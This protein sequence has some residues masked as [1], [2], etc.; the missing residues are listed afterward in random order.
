MHGFLTG[1]GCTSHRLACASAATSS[2]P[3]SQLQPAQ[4]AE[5]RGQGDGDRAVR[6]I[7]A[8]G[9]ARRQR[10]PLPGAAPPVPPRGE[11][12]LRGD[13]RLAGHE[14]RSE[15]HRARR[16]RTAPI[17][18]KP[19]GCCFGRSSSTASRFPSLTVE[20]VN[21]FKWFLAAPPARW[22]GPRHHQRWSPLWRPLEGPLSSAALRQS[23]VILRSLFA[24]LVSQNYSAR[25]RVR[26]RGAAARAERGRSA[27]RER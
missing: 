2:V 24:F 11:E 16:R 18:R 17:E 14:A 21:A 10:R 20:D 1:C 19:S 7:P 27:R 26:G 4:L 3:R 15:R 12:R 8:A 23:I 22:C 13:R 6:K 5:S 25:E 9:G